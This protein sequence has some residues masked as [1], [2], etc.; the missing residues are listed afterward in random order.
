[1]DKEFPLPARFP[2]RLALLLTLIP[3]AS[4]HAVAVLD[5]SGRADPDASLPFD[6]SDVDTEVGD[7]LTRTSISVSR[8]TGTFSY[9]ALADI[10]TPKMQISGTWNNPGGALG[11]FETSLLAAS[12]RIRESFTIDVPAPVDYRVT[13]TLSVTGLLDVDGTNAVAQA[14]LI[15]DPTSPDRLSVAV[16]E[17]Y[18]ANG[19]VDDTLTTSFVFSDDAAFDI[20]TEIFLSMRNIDAAT[21]MRIDFSNTAILSIVIESLAGDPLTEVVLESGSGQFGVNPVPVPAALPLLA[22]ALGVLGWRARRR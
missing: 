13:A 22:S 2:P 7:P 4:A 11:N 3:G 14:L 5:V 15:M 16:S 20:R 1:M 21:A 17:T 12:A 19:E 6:F 9:F 8:S 10:A 18:A